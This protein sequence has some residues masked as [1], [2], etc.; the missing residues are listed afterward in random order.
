MKRKYTIKQI[1]LSNQNWWNFYKMH[2]ENIRVAILIAIAKLLSCKH[3]VR[4]YHEYHCQNPQCNQ[5][6]YV[7]HTCKSKAC[8]S[9]GKKSTE[10]WIQKQ[11]QVLPNTSWQHIT[12]TMPSQLWDFFWH[13]R[14]LLNLIPKIAANCIKKLAKNKN[15]TPGIFIAIHTFGRAGN[16]N[17]H[18]HLST[19]LGGI[20]K[21][22][23]Q[24]K[25][26]FFKQHT[27]MTMWRYEIIKI[28]RKNYLAGNLSLPNKIQEQLNQ[29]FSFNNLLNQLYNK[30]WIVHCSKPSDNHKK[31]VSYLGRYVKR[32]PIAQSKLKHYDGNDIT[33]NYLDHNTNSFRKFTLPVEKFIAKFIQHIPDV[34]F[35][36]I[37]YYGFLAN[38]VRGRLLP[39]VYQ[40]IGQ[41]QPIP[42]PAPSYAQLIKKDFHLNPLQ[43]ILCGQQ[44]I[45]SH[46]H[47]GKTSPG[48]LLLCHQQFALQKK[49]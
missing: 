39:K 14:Y 25:K 8:S 3:V 49:C 22:G 4:G 45:L 2:Q 28:F 7:Y 21:D 18:I 26:L 30:T 13:N 24:W 48:Q 19:T 34:G 23:N 11:N 47:F 46:T 36:M 1:L 33:F 15:V 31:N 43:C 35:H 42:S 37:R 29:N 41:Q 20:T 5:V 6:K 12:F 32:P 44:L 38:R 40:L 10:L 27:L 9:C 16:R 17:V